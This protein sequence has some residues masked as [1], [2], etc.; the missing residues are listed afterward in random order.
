[1]NVL[2]HL[3]ER[4]NKRTRIGKRKIRERGKGKRSAKS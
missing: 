1:M 4:V 3:K 2:D